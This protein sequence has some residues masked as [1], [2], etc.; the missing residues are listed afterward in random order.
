MSYKKSLI[1][2][3]LI[4]VLFA[5]YGFVQQEKDEVTISEMQLPLS[6]EKFSLEDIMQ[7]QECAV[8]T[9]D[10]S[11]YTIKTFF[12]DVWVLADDSLM[13]SEIPVDFKGNVLVKTKI[14]GETRNFLLDSK[15]RVY[16]FE[17]KYY[18]LSESNYARLVD[19]ACVFH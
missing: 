5:A 15:S 9:M 16:S 17:D 3:L 7:C 13:V 14:G 1:I 6:F 19:V 18:K 11:N 10:L 8:R 12:R 4:S 2:L